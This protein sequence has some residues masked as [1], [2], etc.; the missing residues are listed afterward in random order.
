MPSFGTCPLPS[1]TA[2]GS[3]G[4]HPTEQ[5]YPHVFMLV[6]YRQVNADWTIEETAPA[7]FLASGHGL[8][9]LQDRT[10]EAVGQ[11]HKVT[12]PRVRCHA[13]PSPANPGLN[14]L[15]C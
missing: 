8:A 15:P 13:H 6:L 1:R 9:T 10:P 12:A 2:S 7:E 14:P 5:P 3:T 11:P 4:N